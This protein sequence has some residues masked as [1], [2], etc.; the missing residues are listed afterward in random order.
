MVSMHCPSSTC[1]LRTSLLRLPFAF[2]ACRDRRSPVLSLA[3]LITT[4]PGWTRE[5][6]NPLLSHCIVR[7]RPIFCAA[8]RLFLNFLF[9]IF[10]DPADDSQSIGAHDLVPGSVICLRSWGYHNCQP[11][12]KHSPAFVHGV[13][14]WPP[15]RLRSGFPSPVLSP[16]FRR[17][18]LSSHPSFKLPWTPFSITMVSLAHS[19]ALDLVLNEEDGRRATT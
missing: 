17:W 19:P 1:T 14:F 5:W 4:T 3:G 8:I 11:I 9:C 12:R 6:A 7:L 16:G 10:D 13:Y 18:W 2:F 15:A